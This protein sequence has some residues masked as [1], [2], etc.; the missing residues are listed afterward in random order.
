M[1]IHHFNEFKV[2]PQ[3]L[4]FSDCVEDVLDNSDEGKL[5]LTGSSNK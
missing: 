5:P 3:P 4:S 1:K 2:V